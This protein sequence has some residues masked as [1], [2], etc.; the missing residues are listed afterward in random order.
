MLTTLPGQNIIPKELVG[1]FRLAAAGRFWGK[2][3]ERGGKERLKV[4]GFVWGEV[5]L[6]LR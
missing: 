2:C 1:M 4:I 5:V 6:R 3:K